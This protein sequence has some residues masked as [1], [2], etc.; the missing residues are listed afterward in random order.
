MRTIFDVK[1]Y[2]S[3]IHPYKFYKDGTGIYKAPFIWE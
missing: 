1:K 2:D 3:V